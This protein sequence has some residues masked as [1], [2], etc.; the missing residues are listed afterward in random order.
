MFDFLADIFQPDPNFANLTTDQKKQA[1]LLID[2][3]VTIGK[4]ED[5]LSERPGGSYNAQ[6]HHREAR[7]IGEKLDSIGGYLLM[8]K[9]YRNVQRK[10]GKT[11]ASHLEYTWAGIGDWM[12]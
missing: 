7:E 9:A 4:K 11:L 1:K 12:K 2:S 5:F 8:W 3:L 6:C 10:L